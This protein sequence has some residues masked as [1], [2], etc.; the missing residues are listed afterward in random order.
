MSIAVKQWLLQVGAQ[1]SKDVALDNAEPLPAA[2]M[3]AVGG[4]GGDQ[5]GVRKLMLDVRRGQELPD[6]LAA[7]SPSHLQV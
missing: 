6:A 7:L 5:H 1:V 4:G 3:A 2:A